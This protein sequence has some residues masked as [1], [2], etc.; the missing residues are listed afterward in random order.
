M[1]VPHQ[2]RKAVLTAEIVERLDEYLS[3]RHFYRHA[4]SFFLEWEKMEK[5]VMECAEAWRDTRAEIE[6]FVEYLR[7]LLQSGERIA[8]SIKET[9]EAS[10]RGELSSGTA[11]E[12]IREVEE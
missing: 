8:A 9:E 6:L 3:F 11:Q 2:N 1:A 5:L 4:Y 7:D 12:L 10:E